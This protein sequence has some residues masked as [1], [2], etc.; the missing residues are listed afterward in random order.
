MGISDLRPSERPDQGLGMVG[1]A[2]AVA[3]AVAV[4]VAVGAAAPTTTKLVVQTTPLMV[5]L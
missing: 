2:V 1:V 3:G 5:K 4:A